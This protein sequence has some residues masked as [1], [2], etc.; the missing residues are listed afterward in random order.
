MQYFSKLFGEMVTQFLGVV[1]ATST[2]AQTEIGIDIKK[3]IGLGI[4]GASNL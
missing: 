2:T 4:H 3:C 1:E